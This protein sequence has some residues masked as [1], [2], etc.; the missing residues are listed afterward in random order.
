M[1]SGWRLVVVVD[2]SSLQPN[3]HGTSTIV[4]DDDEEK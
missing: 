4:D 3:T 2:R 1:V